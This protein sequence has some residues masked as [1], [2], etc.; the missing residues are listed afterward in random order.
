MTDGQTKEWMDEQ[1]NRRTNERTHRLE[2]MIPI[3][4]A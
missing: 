3:N 1:T 4:E 2:N